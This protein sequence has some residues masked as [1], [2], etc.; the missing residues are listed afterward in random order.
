MDLTALTQ[1]DT[2]RAGTPAVGGLVEAIIA[3]TAVT[4]DDPVYVLIGNAQQRSGPV[5][6]VPR[7]GLMPTR[8]ERCYVQQSSSGKLV[9]VQWGIGTA[10]PPGAGDLHYTHNQTTPAATWTIV[11]PLGKHP[12]VT[13]VDSAGTRLHVGEVQTG[14]TTVTLFF[15]GATTGKAFLN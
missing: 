8:G 6:W 2:Q 7:S 11:H 9:L 3:T 5:E 4:T 1:P 14:P 12:A 10:I 13:V 15:G